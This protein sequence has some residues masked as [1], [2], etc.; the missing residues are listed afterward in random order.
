MNHYKLL[1][2]NILIKPLFFVCLISMLFVVWIL[3]KIIERIFLLKFYLPMVLWWVFWKKTFKLN[4]WWILTMKEFSLWKQ[5]KWWNET[6]SSQLGWPYIIYSLSF[7]SQLFYEN[8][9]SSS[10]DASEVVNLILA[11]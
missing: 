7:N 8:P 5:V 10:W 6:C 1:D 2:L 4:I 3:L 9:I 11:R